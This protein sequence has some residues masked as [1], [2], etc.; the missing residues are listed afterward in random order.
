[1]FGNGHWKNVELIA[2]IFAFSVLAS[3]CTSDSNEA[4]YGSMSGEMATGTLEM[5]I[6]DDNSVTGVFSYNGDDGQIEAEYD[7]DSGDMS[8]TLIGSSGTIIGAVTNRE[9]TGIWSL[10]FDNGD[11]DAGTFTAIKSDTSP[12][13]WECTYSGDGEGTAAFW[14][15]DTTLQ[16]T[17]FV[18]VRSGLLRGEVVGNDISGVVYGYEFDEEIREEY[19]IGTMSG[20]ID[21][22]R[23]S[24]TWEVTFFGEYEGTWTCFKE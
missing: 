14:V 8:G 2:S 12:A 17:Y 11:A 16:G 1:M 22:N 5:S 15:S 6:G 4:Y 10:L 21:G 19:Q 7:P 24:G 18:G 9:I 23:S 3:G 13:I 20:T